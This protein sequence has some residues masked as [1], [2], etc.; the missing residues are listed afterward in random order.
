[1]IR[2]FKKKEIPSKNYIIVI[3]VT[4][5]VVLLMIFIRSF[6]LN[7][8]SS[9]LS[10][11]IFSSQTVNQIHMDDFDFAI[12]EV[13]NS[14]LYVSY[15][16]SNE[17]YSMEK[18]LYKELENNNLLDKIIYLDITKYTKGNKY[19]NILKNKFP[20][21]DNEINSAPMFIYIKDGAAVEAM[22][23]EIKMI[24]YK[25]VNKLVNKYEI[26]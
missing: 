4:I 19:I 13:S 12:R 6:Y 1:M 3:I 23:S 5:L 9:K 24:D 14:I 2:L 10:E 7:Y 17:I 15:T 18:K 20:N 26:E 22:S 11:S 25:T 21:I 16:G 8:K